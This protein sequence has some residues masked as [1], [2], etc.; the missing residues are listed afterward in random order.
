MSL[1]YVVRRP[2]G[3]YSFRIS[4]PKGQREKFDKK[5]IWVSLKTKDRKEAIIKSAALLDHYTQL[6][7]ADYVSDD[8]PLTKPIMHKTCERLGI[9]RLTPETIEAASVQEY[10]AMM[11]QNIEVLK[12]ITKPDIAEVAAIGGAIEDALTLDEMFTRYQ[13]LAAGKWNDLDNRAR[14]KKWNRYREPVED[15]K[16]EMGDIDVLKIRPKDAANYAINLG[17]RIEAGRIKSETAKKKLLFLNAMVRK[18]LL[19]DFPDHKNPFENAEID[20]N[21]NDSAKRLPF[22]EPEIIAL[23]KKLAE[24][25]ANDELKAILQLAE[26]TGTIASEIVL[27]HETDIRL[28]CEIPYIR[29]GKNPN[30]KSLKTENRPRDI[31]LIG[32]ALDIAKRYPK[33]FPRYCRSGGAESLSQSANKIIHQVVDDKSTYSYRHRLIDLLR[34]VPG[35]QDSLLKSIVGHDGS[36][37]GR[38]GDGYSLERKRD[39]MLKAFSIAAEKQRKTT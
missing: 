9:Q 33:G 16:R 12:K 13:E 23:R 27:L 17:K 36:M 2:N 11:S 29:I 39:V 6:L 7:N 18:V 4:V 3:N 5:E 20:H 30:R 14:Q 8:T 32:P 10:V 24:S 35:M 38:Y 15:F 37:T 1:D 31:P 19:A 25:R 28:D 34:E 26:F 21:G 22:T